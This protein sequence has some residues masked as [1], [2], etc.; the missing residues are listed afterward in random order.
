MQASSVQ[1]CHLGRGDRGWGH[2]VP[3]P[4]CLWESTAGRGCSDE[5]GSCH[6][7][8]RA[9]LRDKIN[10]GLALTS[11]DPTRLR[12]LR[13][14]HQGVPPEAAWAGGSARPPVPPSVRLSVC[15]AGRPVRSP[16]AAAPVAAARRLRRR[17]GGGAGGSSLASPW[18]PG[19]RTHP[20][21]RRHSGAGQP[22]GSKDREGTGSFPGEGG[23]CVPSL[24]PRSPH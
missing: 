14:C 24:P 21:G 17:R 3:T 13:R 9:S 18:I 4:A 15:P 23:V 7:G 2:L 19:I 5:I 12:G 1:R 6:E 10:Q 8:W 22:S 20:P 16:G 11:A